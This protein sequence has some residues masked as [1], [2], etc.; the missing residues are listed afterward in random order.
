VSSDQPLH[1]ADSWEA[2]SWENHQV[3]PWD[4]RVEEGAAVTAVPEAV[5][6]AAR[7]AFDAR[8]I[9]TLVADLVFDSILDTD[10]RAVADPTA[11]TMRFGSRDGG[12]DLR[13]VDL[14]T[15]LRVSV[16]V[17]PAQRATAE[18]RCSWPTF[19]VDIDE[20]GTCEFDVPSGLFSLVL[21]PTRAP[22]NRPLQTSWVR[23]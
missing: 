3:R 14:G 12:V 18:V 22:R 7:R 20:A 10:R 8:P 9:D 16:N 5:R 1:R 13:I 23:L 15:Q 11:R 6:D 4:V 2:D 19:T 21:R 17:L